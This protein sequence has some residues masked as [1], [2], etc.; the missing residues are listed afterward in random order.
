MLPRVN[1]VSQRKRHGWG[2]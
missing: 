1:H 2:N